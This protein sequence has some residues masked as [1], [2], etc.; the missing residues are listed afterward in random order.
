MG[1]ECGMQCAGNFGVCVGEGVNLHT[2]SFHRFP[3][4]DGQ[5]ECATA[6]VYLSHVE[7]AEDEQFTVRVMVR[8]ERVSE[9]PKIYQKYDLKIF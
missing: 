2:S 9:G 6:H 8:N 4:P 7:I 5:A 3:D 1:Y